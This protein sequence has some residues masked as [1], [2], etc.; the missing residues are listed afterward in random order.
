[1]TVHSLAPVDSHSLSRA[2][3]TA[4]PGS[5]LRAAAGGT[6]R[7]SCTFSHQPQR[8]VGRDDDDR[9][10]NDDEEE[11]EEVDRQVDGDL[12]RHRLVAQ[13]VERALE[14]AQLRVRYPVRHRD[15]SP[16]SGRFEYLGDALPGRM[17]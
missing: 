8:R 4:L 7:E 3:D 11:R 2:S 9:D 1:M 16:V 12:A 17:V 5:A 14:A 6:R 13:A 10:D 15:V